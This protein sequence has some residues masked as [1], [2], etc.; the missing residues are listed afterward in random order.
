[1]SKT[2]IAIPL[3]DGVTLRLEANAGYL[4]ENVLSYSHPKKVEHIPQAGR[5]YLWLFQKGTEIGD[6]GHV[7]YQP[8]QEVGV[9]QRESLI[10]MRDA[11]D[12]AIAFSAPPVLAEAT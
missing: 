9:C 5:T 7:S 2:D 12:A 11:L 8:T 10:A 1:M 6:E 3:S 4:K